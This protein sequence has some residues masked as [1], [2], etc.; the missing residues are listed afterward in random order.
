MQRHNPRPA[1]RY[2]GGK[3]RLAPWIIGHFPAHDVYV[4]AFGGAAGVLLQKR[5][6]RAEVYNDL[7]GDMVAFFRVLRDPEERS[8]LIDACALTP[9]ARDEF[10]LAWEP[11]AEPVE[12]ARRTAVRAQ[13]GFSPGGACRA[14]T[15]FRNDTKRGATAQ[16][17]WANYPES[18][19]TVGARFRSVVIENRPALRVMQDHDGASTLHFV[20]P[21]YLHATRSIR[22]QGGYQHELSAE[23][24][25]ALLRGIGEL[26]G[27]VVLCGYESE[28][29]RNELQGWTT[30][31]KATSASG[32]RGG[33]K[34]REYLWLNRACVA[35]LDN[36]GLFGARNIHAGTN[37]E[38]SDER[39]ARIQ[40]R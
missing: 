35:A 8:R 38:A 26:R 23:D 37:E 20:D 33:T 31:T 18:L 28:L 32:R 27:M 25:E 19:A 14:V 15:G 1:M 29:Y 6:S 12:R 39:A 21:P 34:R 13:M 9:Y 11:C 22:S 40:R 16:R 5:P 4:E 3:F 17:E 2:L 30:T 7:D 24:H 36:G 10:T